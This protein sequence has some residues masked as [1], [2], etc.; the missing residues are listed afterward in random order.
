MKLI[1]DGLIFCKERWDLDVSIEFNYFVIVLVC[2]NSVFIIEST[3]LCTS[4][5]I[6]R[7][8]YV[9]ASR[10]SHVRSCGSTNTPS[11]LTL[12]SKLAKLNH[13]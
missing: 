8:M 7:V 4:V 2:Y 10:S 5:R 1:E 9:H 6:D 11:P 12:K 13:H 3:E